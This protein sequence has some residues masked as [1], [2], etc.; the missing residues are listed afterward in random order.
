MNKVFKVSESPHVRGSHSTRRI[1]LDV[2]IALTPGAVFGI[3][4]FGPGA[5][6]RLLVGIGVCIATEAIYQAAMKKKV[7]AAKVRM[8]V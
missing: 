3:F 2:I 4:N 7:M 5:L 1:M 6:I 8:S